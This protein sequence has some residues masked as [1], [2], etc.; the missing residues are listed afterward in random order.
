[1]KTILAPIDFSGVTDAVVT[2][3]ATLARALDGKVVLFTVI[4]PP[5]MPM[6][7]APLMADI[8]EITSAGEKNADRDL[9]KIEARLQTGF[10]PAESLHQVGSPVPLILAQAEEM[11]ADNIV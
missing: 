7:Y 2:A 10:I 1:M 6:E 8:A 4:Q 5:A 3:A 9:A 11:S